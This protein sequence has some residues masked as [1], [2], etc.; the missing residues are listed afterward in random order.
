MHFCIYAITFAET[1]HLRAVL[2]MIVLDDDA[3]GWVLK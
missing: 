1:L 3:P 2:P